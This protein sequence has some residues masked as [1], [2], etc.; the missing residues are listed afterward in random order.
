MD[1][2]QIKPSPPDTEEDDNKRLQ[3]LMTI[4]TNVAAG[5]FV[6]VFLMYFIN[7]G[8][9][10]LSPNN[11]DWGTFGDFVGGIL[12]PTIA[13]LALYWLITSVNLQIKELKKTNEALAATVKT[14]KEQQNQV[15]IQNFESLFFQLLR[16]KD[17]ALND[18]IY[19]L[20]SIE[21]NTSLKSVDAIKQHIIKFKSN[22]LENWTKYYENNMLDYTGSYF[23]IC[24]QIVKLI[25]Q[26]N[27]LTVS[28]APDL[29]RTIVYSSE[30][31]K[32]FDIFRA[33]LTKHE[34]E[35]FFFNCLSEYGNVKF[36]KIIEKYG[37]FEPLPIDLYR[38]EEIIHRLTKYA[39]QYESHIFERNQSWTKYFKDISKINSKIDKFELISIFKMMK[40]LEILKSSSLSNMRRIETNNPILIGSSYKFN[41]ELKFV[42]LEE[43]IS[44]ENFN[45]IEASYES[46]YSKLVKGINDSQSSIDSSKSYIKDIKDEYT[47]DGESIDENKVYLLEEMWD[48]KY[49]ISELKKIISTSENSNA[50]FKNDLESYFK[51]KETIKNSDHTITVLTLVKYGIDYTEYCEYMNSKQLVDNPPQ[52]S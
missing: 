32:Y 30:Q 15:S 44:D 7:F 2:P 37:L 8:A 28:I 5:I 19:V 36:K 16:T 33:T 46:Y 20:G 26:N 4:S 9:L 24:Y 52:Q 39:Y 42:N 43:I 34:L 47:K 17:D 29:D 22:P 40:K 10:G 14:A 25:D 12:N 23:R 35:A 31:K 11:G 1:N 6:F 41:I 51:N 3:I 38:S 50:K 49:S 48:I 13:G 45:K 21:E 18:I 27:I